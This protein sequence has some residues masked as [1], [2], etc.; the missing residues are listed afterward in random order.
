M[1]SEYNTLSFIL[2]TYAHTYIHTY[3]YFSPKCAE[4]TENFTPLCIKQVP[5]ILKIKTGKNWD[6]S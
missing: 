1:L 5:S 3:I 6:E 2:Y 4:Y